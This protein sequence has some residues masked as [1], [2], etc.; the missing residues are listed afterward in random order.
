MSDHPFDHESRNLEQ[1]M[2]EAAEHVANVAHVEKDPLLIILWRLNHQDKTLGAI[3][4]DLGLVGKE[5]SDHIA[6]EDVIKESI[7]EMVVTWK[8]S[9]IAGRVMSWFVWDAAAIG[10]VNANIKRGGP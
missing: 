9:K 1:E 3:K 8:G 2:L 4:H 10:A 5:L 7:D 6:R